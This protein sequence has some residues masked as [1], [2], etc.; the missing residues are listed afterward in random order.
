VTAD[1]ALQVANAVSNP[2]LFWALRGGG[3][4]TFGV[5]VEA[6]VKAYPNERISSAEFVISSDTKN[7]T[8]LW[9]A[10]TYFMTQMPEMVKN[11]VSGYFYFQ[12]SS[13]RASM[14]HP[15]NTSGTTNVQAFWKPYLAKMASFHSMRPTNVTISNYGSYKFYF[16]AIFGSI[17]KVI[18]D[19]CVP[20]M[21]KRHGPGMEMS[22]PTPSGLSALDSRLLGGSHMASPGLANALKASSP[23]LQ[24]HLVAN[25]DLKYENTSVLPAW[26]SAYVHMIGVR[27]GSSS[28]DPLRKLAPDMGAYANEVRIPLESMLRETVTAP[29][30]PRFPVI[31]TIF[32]KYI[33]L[34]TFV[35]NANAALGPLG[36]R[37]LENNILGL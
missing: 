32:P 9:D 20:G 22:S 35:S 37:K 27:T 17:D 12:S 36:R 21:R 23:Y 31:S 7:S 26:R 10:Y 8:G 13:I 18:D 19:G 29:S 1:G 15:G 24:G 25:P 33:T 2:D 28:V 16:D 6:T 11:G 3:G 34:S 30:L 14:V 5:V 4:S